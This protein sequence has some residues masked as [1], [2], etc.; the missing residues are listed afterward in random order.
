MK[1][2]GCKFA[3]RCAIATD[4]CRASRPPL[5]EIAPGHMVKCWRAPIEELN[6]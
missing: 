3:S 5:R 1:I 6:P 2:Q 4:E